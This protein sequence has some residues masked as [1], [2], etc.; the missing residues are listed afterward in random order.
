M[1]PFVLLKARVKGFRVLRWWDR[2][3]EIASTDLRRHADN[4]GLLAVLIFGENT[5]EIAIVEV[6]SN[7][8]HLLLVWSPGFEFVHRL[9]IAHVDVGANL[10]TELTD[11]IHI[12]VLSKCALAL[13][14][15][16]VVE[17]LDFTDSKT[18]PPQ[19]PIVAALRGR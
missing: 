2:A 15:V 9:W 14:M 5:V 19:A 17:L 16:R 6:C 13:S 8:Y 1:L 7:S 12:E 4:M 10:I 11:S 18:P 3:Y